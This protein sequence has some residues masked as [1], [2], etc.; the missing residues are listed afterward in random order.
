[1]PIAAKPSSRIVSIVFPFL[2]ITDDD[3]FFTSDPRP[4]PKLTDNMPFNLM[5]IASTTSFRNETLH[6]T[7]EHH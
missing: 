3:N 5:L 4:R 6:I 2:L 1:M 7:Y